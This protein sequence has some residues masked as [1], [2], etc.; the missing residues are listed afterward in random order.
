MKSTKNLKVRQERWFFI[1]KILSTLWKNK[2]SFTE[3]FNAYYSTYFTLT[4]SKKVYQAYLCSAKVRNTNKKKPKGQTNK[5]M[6]RSISKNTPS[7][8]KRKKRN[9]INELC[10][11]FEKIW[12]K[13]WIRKYKLNYFKN[14]NIKIWLKTF[15]NSI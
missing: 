13:L 8:K 4:T 9:Q 1:V 14:Q 6:K 5:T 3:M 15:I 2:P 10:I 12:L 7:H 11:V